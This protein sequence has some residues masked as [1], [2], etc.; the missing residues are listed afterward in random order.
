PGGGGGAGGP[1][2]AG[3]VPLVVV[4]PRPEQQLNGARLALVGAGLLLPPDAP[5]VRVSAA[6]SG[7]LE[8]PSYASAARELRAEVRSMPGPEEAVTW[9]TSPAQA[10]RAP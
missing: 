8:Q 1:A 7:L 6:L 10:P 4:A 9:L 5:A 2:R 3:G